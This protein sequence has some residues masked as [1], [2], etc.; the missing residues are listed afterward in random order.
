MAGYTKTT[1]TDKAVQFALR[2]LVYDDNGNG[3]NLLPSSFASWSMNASY[4]TVQAPD[5]LK[6][7]GAGGTSVNTN[8]V[9]DN[10]SP[11]TAYTLSANMTRV[12]FSAGGN[13][14][15]DAEFLD[16]SSV[17]I[18]NTTNIGNDN[19]FITSTFTTPSNCAKIRIR[20]VINSVETSSAIMTITDPMLELGSTA[21]VRTAHTIKQSSGLVTQTGTPVNAANLNKMEQGIDEAHSLDVDNVTIA[22]TVV[23]ASDTVAPKTFFNNV[24]NMI[25]QITGKANWRTTPRTTLENAVKLNGD[26]MTGNLTVPK[27]IVNG[28]SGSEG[29]EIELQKPVSGTTLAGNVLVDIASDKIRFFENGGGFRG[30]NLPITSQSGVDSTVILTTNNYRTTNGYVEWYNGSTWQGV[31][32]VKSVQRGVATIAA[33]SAIINVTISAVNLSKTFVN[34]SMKTAVE[35]S[36]YWP[37]YVETMGQL[38]STTNLEL[39]RGSSGSGAS[40]TISWE[41]I[42]SY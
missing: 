14:Y 15:M 29:G 3:G 37:S 26:T 31:G 38:T 20:C 8:T 34:I 10:I 23:P 21:T 5:Q 36:S 30:A 12:G 11:N 35:T 4:N 39:T 33:A 18:S 7:I 2:Y 16:A 1:W 6:I 42:E 27:V 17:A 19:A 9:V 40:V 22:D 28:S 32:G 13:G 41:V 24:A 25:K